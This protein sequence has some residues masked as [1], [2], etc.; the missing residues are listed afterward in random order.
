MAT[1]EEERKNE[2]H[3]DDAEKTRPH[4]EVM[5][6]PSA[7][8]DPLGLPEHGNEN[9]R[10]TVL[11]PLAS[12]GVEVWRAERSLRYWRV[13]HE[14]YTFCTTEAG[15]VGICH[16]RY[17]RREFSMQPRTQ[18]I[19]EPGHSHHTF[20]IGGPPANFHVLLV[21]PQMMCELLGG[22]VPHFARGDSVDP[23]L[24][25]LLRGVVQLASTD[26]ESLEVALTE[27]TAALIDAVGERP[28]CRR[29]VERHDWRVERVRQIIHDELAEPL[30]LRS[31]ARVVDLSPERIVNLFREW[32]GLPFRQYV[33][34][35]RLERAMGL[36]RH[37]VSPSAAALQTGF[38]DLRHMGREMKR[39]L[40]FTPS[41]YFAGV[42]R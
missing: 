11:R 9:E 21:E 19:F 40:G 2:P 34:A 27:Y 31:L 18:R 37:G 28:L 39:R 6:V 3:E 41:H 13:F 10:I 22:A 36:M 42:G 4:V 26:P 30:Q 29:R 15:G 33:I 24:Q 23:G 16:W 17:R 7:L 1:S 20:R 38:Y 32:T 14:R 25:Q 5:R 8:I 12:P 35:T